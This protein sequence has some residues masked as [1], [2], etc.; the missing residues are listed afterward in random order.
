MV[1]TARVEETTSNRVVIGP[2]A[3]RVLGEDPSEAMAFNPCQAIRFGNEHS[4]REPRPFPVEDP[5]ALQ[6]RLHTRML[7]EVRYYG[8]SRDLDVMFGQVLSTW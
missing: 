4:A 2:D 6:F 3:E 5:D 7:A 1:L 8:G